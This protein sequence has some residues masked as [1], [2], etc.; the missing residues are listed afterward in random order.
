MELVR[1]GHT[2]M[3]ISVTLCNGYHDWHPLSYSGLWAWGR[4][5]RLTFLVGSVGPLGPWSHG[6]GIQSIWGGHVYTIARIQHPTRAL[7]LGEELPSAAQ[8]SWKGD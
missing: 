2:A 3:R 1:L 4:R 6:G 8:G 5:G 7:R